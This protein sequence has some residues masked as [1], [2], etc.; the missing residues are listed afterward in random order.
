MS[1][2]EAVDGESESR[3]PFPWLAVVMRSLGDISSVEE[4]RALSSLVHPAT[5]GADG[6]TR[7]Y[8][9]EVLSATLEHHCSERA[10]GQAADCS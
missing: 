1:A 7:G 8:H 5:H 3:K 10:K 6:G 4:L 2:G 9:G